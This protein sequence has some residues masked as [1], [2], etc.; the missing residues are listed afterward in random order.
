[1]KN[2]SKRQRDL[3]GALRIITR[4]HNG[5][6][7]TWSE[8]EWATTLCAKEAKLEQAELAETAANE[9]KKQQ[10]KE[11][12]EQRIREIKAANKDPAWT[13]R[14]LNRVLTGEG[15]KSD[16]ESDSDLSSVATDISA[17][18]PDRIPQQVAV[19]DNVTAVREPGDD[20]NGRND[21][22]EDAVAPGGVPC[23]KTLQED[24]HH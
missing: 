11:D 15:D 10:W 22:T 19:N 17:L 13:E 3:E 20:E 6:S 24:T 16:S 9:S 21:L 7:V 23:S 12:Q 4:R 8:L 2:K 14:M 5:Q 18:D 1:V